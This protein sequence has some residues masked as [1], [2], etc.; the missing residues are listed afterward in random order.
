MTLAVVFTPAG[1]ITTELRG[2]IVFVVDVL[3]AGTTICAALSN[4]ARAVIPVADTQEALRLAQTLG[5][6][7]T[8]LAGERLCVRIPGFALGNS[9]REMVP[10]VVSGKTVIMTTT[11][12]TAALLAAASAKEVYLAGAANF[13]VSAALASEAWSRQ[14][15]ILIVCAGREQAFALDDAYTAGRLVEAAIGGGRGR[16]GLNDAA[17]AALDLVR[18]YG[19]RW[20]RPLAASQGGRDLIQVG[21]KEDI[22]DAAREDAYPVVATFANGRVT[23]APARTVTQT[24]STP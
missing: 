3:R 1:L 5:A 24:S 14:A 22:A 13:S 20:D 4:G 8:L 6:D 15:E 7:E 12:G 2:R 23:A 21:M 11:N 16:K 10:E 19:R 17:L 9:P 18:R